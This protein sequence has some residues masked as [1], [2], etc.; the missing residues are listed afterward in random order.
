MTTRRH[1][2]HVLSLVPVAAATSGLVSAQPAQLAETDP[3]AVALGYRHDATKVDASKYPTWAAGRVC[4]NCQLFQGKPS[5]AWAPCG[6]MGGKLV[7]AKGWCTAWSK[8]A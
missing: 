2:L 4:S 6:V 3:Q 7:N 8:K 5:D 1:M